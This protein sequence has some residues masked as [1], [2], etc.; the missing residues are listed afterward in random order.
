MSETVTPEIL[1]QSCASIAKNE[2]M[3]LHNELTPTAVRNIRIEAQAQENRN[4]SI[5]V[6]GLITVDDCIALS[7]LRKDLVSHSRIVPSKYG[8]SAKTTST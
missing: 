4:K 1:R 6:N 2:P 3:V 7:T 8:D 5:I